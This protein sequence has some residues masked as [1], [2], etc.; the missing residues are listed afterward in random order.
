MPRLPIDLIVQ[1][2]LHATAH[3][4]WGRSDPVV[5]L[6]EASGV[7][8]PDVVAEITAR[9]LLHAVAETAPLAATAAVPLP[10]SLALLGVPALLLARRS[11][12]AR[13]RDTTAGP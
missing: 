4:L 12:S 3:R 8:T 13:G 10:P 2:E 5:V 7:L 1:N 6:A 11:R 9:R